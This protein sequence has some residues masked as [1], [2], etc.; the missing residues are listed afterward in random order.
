MTSGSP[1]ANARREFRRFVLDHHPDRG[2]DPAVFRA[3]VASY[4]AV[5]ADRPLVEV[6][7]R[8]RGPAAV[9]DH[10]RRARERRRRPPRV[11]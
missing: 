9:I 7:R 3:G 4:R 5:V 2:G 10:L 11:R 6:Y 8:R 1:D